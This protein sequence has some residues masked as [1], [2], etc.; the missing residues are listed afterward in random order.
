MFDTINVCYY[1]FEEVIDLNI[2]E[3]KEKAIKLLTQ[4]QYADGKRVPITEIARQLGIGRSM[5]YL[6]RED[7]S[8]IPTRR[9]KAMA[10][11]YDHLNNVNSFET[12]LKN[13]KTEDD[14]FTEAQGQI[15]QIVDAGINK[16]NTSAYTRDILKTFV[17]DISKPSSDLLRVLVDR[18]KNE[19]PD[20]W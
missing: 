13:V 12:L 14:L 9:I 15:S 19:N 10:E 6:Y 4:D 11:Y 8:K 5:I 3:E 7:Y 16:V 17:S 18:M 20:K 1:M 2:D